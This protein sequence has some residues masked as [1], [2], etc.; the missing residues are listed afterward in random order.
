MNTY[1]FLQHYWWF[2]VSLLEAILVFAVCLVQ[3]GSFADILSGQDGR[4]AQ[5]DNKLYG[6]QV[7]VYVYYARNVRRCVLCIVPV[8]LQYEL[9]RCVLAVDDYLVYFR[10][11]GCKLRVS[12]KAGNLLGKTTYRAFLV[13]NGVV[14]RCCWAVR[15]QRSSRV[16][17]SY[18]QRR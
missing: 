13:M 18:Q 2:I 5:D 9:R 15:W 12:S 16:R 4:T 17:S 10:V 6:A 11:A 14:G 3:G 8:V 7:G 1:I